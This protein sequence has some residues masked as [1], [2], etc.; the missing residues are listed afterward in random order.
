MSCN[1]PVES[2]RERDIDLLLVE[3]FVSSSAFVNFFTQQLRLPSCDRVISV[4]RSI[5]DF[6]LGETDVLLCYMTQDQEVRVLIED[7]LDAALQTHQSRRYNT[8]AQ[9]YRSKYG[10]KAYCVLVAPQQYIDQQTEFQRCLSYESVA[11]YFRECNLGDRG[12]FKQM[13][14]KIAIEK[15]RR[16]YAA[17]NCLQNQSFWR[18]YHDYITT[19]LPD[20]YMKPVDVVPAGSDWINLWVGGVGIVHKLQ[21]GHIDIPFD[22]EV[23]QQLLQLSVVVDE[24]EFAS[25]RFLRVYTSPLDRM[26]PFDEQIG[27]ISKSIS[28]IKKVRNSIIAA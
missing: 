24:V 4:E 9:H 8:R 27:A 23:K 2:V 26:R 28:D 10:C 11:D 18:R 20:T 22:S 12:H 6:G 5:H 19:A 16:G 21:K 7:K 14:L 25:G 1:L 3:E 13:I 17:V 15:L